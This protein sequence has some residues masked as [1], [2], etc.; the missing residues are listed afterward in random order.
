[1]LEHW[2]LG[3]PRYHIYSLADDDHIA[4][5]HHADSDDDA[6]AILVAEQLLSHTTYSSS[7]IWQ[8]NKLVARIAVNAAGAASSPL[9]N[10]APPE[11]T[12]H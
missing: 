4:A 8:G 10:T 12:R 1:M 2:R 11:M 9:A 5:T 6:T 7:E 3:M